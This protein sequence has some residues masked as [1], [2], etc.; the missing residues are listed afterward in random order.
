MKVKNPKV[1]LIFGPS[2]SGK[3]TLARRVSRNKGWVYFCE[4]DFWYEYK[5]K[6]GIKNEHVRHAHQ[7]REVFQTVLGKVIKCVMSGK[8][9][10]LEFVLYEDPPRPLQYYYNHLKKENI[11]LKLIG[12]KPTIK[13]ILKRQKN[14]GRKRD[15]EIKRMKMEA[16]Q[17][18]K[19]LS[20]KYINDQWIIRNNK[21]NEETY[22][23]YLKNWINKM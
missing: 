17:Q 22:Q 9:V 5:K 21:T 3:G 13:N 11:D 8:N 4:D 1:I 15:E 6:R 23:E 12:L 19:A 7:Q 20:S 16:V 14:R 2:G 10:V 18:L